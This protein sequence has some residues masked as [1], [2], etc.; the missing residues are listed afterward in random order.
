MKDSQKTVKKI[1]KDSEQVLNKF[2]SRYAKVF[3]LLGGVA[4]RYRNLLLLQH[5]L[6]LSFYAARYLSLSFSL[7]LILVN[8]G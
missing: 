2:V 7:W 1:V 3:L 5:I 4:I 8:F 6:F